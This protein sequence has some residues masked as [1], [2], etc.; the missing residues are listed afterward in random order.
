MKKYTKPIS[1]IIGLNI[2]TLLSNSVTNIST[3]DP[4]SNSTTTVINGGV[5]G[6]DVNSGIVSADSKVDIWS[7]E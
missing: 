6:S 7:W 3:T 1:T 5:I 4:L 2:D